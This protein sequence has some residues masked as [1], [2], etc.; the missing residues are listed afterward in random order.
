MMGFV[1]TRSY[2]LKC[3]KN[4][5]QSTINNISL[6]RVVETDRSDGKFTKQTVWQLVF[7]TLY[8]IEFILVN[9]FFCSEHTGLTFVIS[10]VIHY[11]RTR[12]F[13]INRGSR[14]TL[15]I[16]PVLILEVSGRLKSGISITIFVDFRKHF[17]FQQFFLG[18]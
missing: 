6:R 10:V 18:S 1:V 12:P 5:A 17:Y 9:S 7:S 13:L 16:I 8:K 11:L 4:C 14:Q 2:R 15:H 3:Q